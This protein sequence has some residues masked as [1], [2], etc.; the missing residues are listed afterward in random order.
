MALSLAPKTIQLRRAGFFA[1]LGRRYLAA[2]GETQL[3][4]LEP[5]YLRKSAAEEKRASHKE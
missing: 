4:T 3:D 2:G 1:A 5:I